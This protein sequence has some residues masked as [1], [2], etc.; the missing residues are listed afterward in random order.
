MK[1]SACMMVK[2]EEEMLAR[3]LESIKDEVDEIVVVD[4]GS[5]DRTVEIARQ[6]TDRI[7]YHEW[8]DDF[9]G[10]RNITMSYAEGDYILIL[11][12]DDEFRRLQPD[13]SLKE[14]LEKPLSNIYRFQ[15]ENVRT[16]NVPT[17][18][19]NQIRLFRNGMEFKYRGIVHN[20]FDSKDERI[21]TAPFL[22][23]HY[24]Y[25]LD[26]EK[27]ELKRQRSERLL[28]KM[29]EQGEN[30]AFAHYQLSK[31]HASRKDSRKSL[32]SALNAHR[33]MGEDPKQL[34]YQDVHYLIAANAF[35]LDDLE[36]TLE[37]TRK[38]LKADPNN[39]DAAFILLGYYYEKK[40]WENFLK[41]YPRYLKSRKK[42]VEHPESFPYI[43]NMGDH[44]ADAVYMYAEA[45]IRSGRE[46]N[47]EAEIP[48]L[49]GD[50]QRGPY[51]LNLLAAVLLECGKRDKA[52]SLLQA[53]LKMDPDFSP[54]RNNLAALQHE[55]KV[56]E[57][58]LEGP[59]KYHLKGD[60]LLKAR[61]RL[62]L[63]AKHLGTGQ[64]ELAEP[65]LLWVLD[66]VDKGGISGP[67]R[68]E[69][70]APA[71]EGLGVIARKRGDDER[72]LEYLSK[73]VELE[74]NRLE[75][76]L[77]LAELLKSKQ[78]FSEALEH[79]EAAVSCAP[80]SRNALLTR[81][82]VHRE[83]GNLRDAEKDLLLLVKM[84][85]DFSLGTFNLG[86]LYWT[87]GRRLD[88]LHWLGRTMRM[89]P[90]NSEYVR[91]YFDVQ[92]GVRRNPTISLC[93]MVKNEQ[94]HFDK[95]LASVAG[96][97]DEIVI[98][99][100]GSEDRTVEI[101]ESYG[102]RLYRHPW[103]DDFSG[104]RNITLSYARGEWILIL[105]GD[106]ALEPED[107]DQ[108]RKD[109]G[110]LSRHAVTLRVLNYLEGK[111][112]VAEQNSI[113]LIRNN[114]GFHYRGIV[115]NQLWYFGTGGSSQVR[116]HH[117]GYDISPEKKQK[118][119]DRTASLLE[120][121]IDQNPDDLDAHYYLI[122]SYRSVGRLDDALREGHKVL[123][124]AKKT[125]LG[126][127]NQYYADVYPHLGV[128]PYCQGRMGEGVAH[129]GGRA[130]GLP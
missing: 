91:A 128:S 54:A 130:R 27:M 105:D 13:L 72:S 58:N 119:F 90:E 6:Y 118:K 71:F 39:M 66:L 111:N 46:E 45:L 28:E 42:Y 92:R 19:F 106:E 29:I 8:F 16:A 76:H 122:S 107:V 18:T 95:C 68:A 9:S 97:V 100:T 10:M 129:T 114:M 17:S 75:A 1:I 69:L 50:P 3:A 61:Q 117:Y 40:D 65:C 81:A 96:A 85:P 102:A 23:L 33:A 104:M 99:D 89:A 37:E 120:T 125:G 108:L 127:A 110:D 73:A 4:T 34:I 51:F 60:P 32:E 36:T 77:Q 55:E 83:A 109:A 52:V 20:Q 94:V 115:H 74:P 5:T 126:L 87:V 21:G 22:I 44:H 57:K 11:D 112:R 124:L 84:Y 48:E 79:A 62:E 64:F 47:L 116:I 98:V 2:N 43:I 67:E 38:M 78:R 93:M 26:D 101:A 88:A 41:Y 53:A 15:L 123:E 82:L 24:G 103:F 86:S 121:R 113:R 12:A 35:N 31:I 14:F 25:G 30:V 80:E 70:L 56:A 49:I 7:Y 63:G 59:V